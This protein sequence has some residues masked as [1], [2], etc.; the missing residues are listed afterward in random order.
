[1]GAIDFR[2]ALEQFDAY[3]FA[4]RHGGY[5]ESAS[6]RSHEYLLPCPWCTSSRLRWNHP[7]KKGFTCWGCNQNGST[8]ELIAKIENCSFEAAHTLVLEGYVGGDASLELKPITAPT[9]VAHAITA[10]PWPA[11]VDVLSGSELH[12]PAWLYLTRR[13]VDPNTAMQ[14]RLGFGRFGR[15]KDYI[16]FPVFMQGELVYWQGRSIHDPPRGL[17][18]EG[19]KEWIREHHYIKSI[20][21]VAMAGQA[22]AGDVLLNYDRA[23]HEP[24]VVIVEGPFDNIKIGPHGT[25][26]LGKAATDAKIEKL[27][28]M[29]AQRYTIYLD[30]GEKERA[31]A[32]S[33]AQRLSNYVPTHIAVPPEGYDPGSLSPE[34][35]AHVIS[36][37]PRFDRMALTGV[38]L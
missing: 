33:L 6:L 8:I 25:G 21:P 38:H 28:S 17:T 20:N 19:R 35:N 34:Q 13:G 5:K 29:R 22:T 30:R 4:V 27:L 14:W 36:A 26:L 12:R 18:P 23:R 7:T 24:H 31:S 1:M 37:A 16:I 11:G 2:R 10:I 9:R 3:R 15:V 32:L